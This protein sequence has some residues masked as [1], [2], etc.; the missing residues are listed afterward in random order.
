MCAG[1]YRVIRI[2]RRQLS[3]R[4]GEVARISAAM[5]PVNHGPRDIPAVALTFD[6]GPGAIT[7]RVLDSLRE[8][9]APGAV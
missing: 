4:P 9:G 1:A 6:D 7:P 3:T 2:T 8:A 5:R